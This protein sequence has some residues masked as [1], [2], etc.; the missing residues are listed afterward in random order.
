M[1][2]IVSYTSDSVSQ[3]GGTQQIFVEGRR[4]A[5]EDWDV[6]WCQGSIESESTSVV[7]DCVWPH[8][9]APLSLD[10]SKQGYYSEEPFPSPGDLPDPGIKPRSPALQVDSL[11]PGSREANIERNK[12][13]G[14]LNIVHDGKYR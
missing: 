9:Q 6:V 12:Q 4:L 2:I 13:N 1:F 10:F 5:E 14:H 7:S 8:E 3:V 11:P